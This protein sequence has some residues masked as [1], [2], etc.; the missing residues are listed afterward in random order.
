MVSPVGVK[1]SPCRKISAAW[2]VPSD[3]M[4]WG[5]R[6]RVK[7]LPGLNLNIGKRGAGV[8]GGRRGARVS[9]SSRGRRS[10][11]LGW[12]GLFWRKKL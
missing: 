5:Y 7:L 9:A 3:T 6:K 1:F 2:Q 4:S 10:L 8:S 11:S 12:K